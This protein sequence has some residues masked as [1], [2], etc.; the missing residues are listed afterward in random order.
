MSAWIVSK[1][2]ID[3]LVTA[4]VTFPAVSHPD[5][6]GAGEGEKG[7]VPVP[8]LPALIGDAARAHAVGRML[9]TENL[10]SVMARYPRDGNGQRPT[11]QQGFRDEHVTTYRFRPIPGVICPVVVLKNIECYEYQSSEHHGWRDSEAKQ[12]CEALRGATISRLPGFHDAP[13]GFD[14][15]RYFVDLTVVTSPPHGDPP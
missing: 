11:A 4:G 5:W 14:D 15:R 7:P 2:H 13:W 12:F 9:W 10:A 1:T 8:D 3:L 6:T